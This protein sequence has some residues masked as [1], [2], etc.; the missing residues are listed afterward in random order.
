MFQSFL[1]VYLLFHPSII[2]TFPGNCRKLLCLRPQLISTRESTGNDVS[3]KWISLELVCHECSAAKSKTTFQL[4]MQIV[5]TVR[6]ATKFV[7]VNNSCHFSLYSQK[8]KISS[9]CRLSSR[10]QNP[11]KY[12]CSGARRVVESEEMD[13]AT[14]KVPTSISAVLVSFEQLWPMKGTLKREFDQ[15]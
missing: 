1:A 4:Q 10:S 3:S 8:N 7:V 12:V 5:P 13:S 9:C 2:S 15:R 14:E 11:I 6:A